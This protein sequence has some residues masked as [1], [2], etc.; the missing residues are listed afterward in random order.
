MVRLSPSI[1]Q[2]KHF[3]IVKLTIWVRCG[4][5]IMNRQIVYMFTD[6][7]QQIAYMVK[8]LNYAWLTAGITE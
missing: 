8:Q 1:E 2:R 5:A 3:I 6:A 4:V 7:S